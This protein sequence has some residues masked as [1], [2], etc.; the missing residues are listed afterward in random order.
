MNKWLQDYVYRIN[1]SW[2]IF[3]AGGIAAIIIAPATV[4]FQAMKAAVA[5]PVESL[6]TE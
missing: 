6:R 5:N 1:L 3:P 2:W 4:S